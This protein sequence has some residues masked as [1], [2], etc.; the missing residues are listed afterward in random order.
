MGNWHL[1][2]LHTLTMYGLGA[3]ESS[4]AN[5]PLDVLVQSSATWEFKMLPVNAAQQVKWPVP[6]QAQNS[7]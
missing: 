3:Q 2:L 5:K 7:L 1:I 4:I 6:G